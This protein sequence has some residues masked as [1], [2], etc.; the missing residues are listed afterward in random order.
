MYVSPLVEIELPIIGHFICCVELPL[1]CHPFL[2]VDPIQGGP[3]PHHYF[4]FP[5]LLQP[6]IQAVQEA[7]CTLVYN[8]TLRKMWHLFSRFHY[9]I[10][11]G[12]LQL[13]LMIV[14]RVY[15]DGPMLIFHIDHFNYEVCIS[16]G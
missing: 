6:F 3:F 7:V 1:E 4:R 11:F 8:V 12:F 2:S 14:H 16:Q 10:S 13:F 9:L 5:E 15:M